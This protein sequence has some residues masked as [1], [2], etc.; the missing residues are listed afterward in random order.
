MSDENFV[1]R[2]LVERA[3]QP[4]RKAGRFAWH[5]ARGKLAGDQIFRVLVTHGLIPS[6]CRILD[7]GCGQALLAAWLAAVWSSYGRGEWPANRPPAPEMV[8]YRGIEL[9]AADLGWGQ[10]ALG[11]SVQ[12]EQGDIRKA[13]FGQADLV[14]IM[15]VLHYLSF[16]D[17]E[18]ILGRAHDALPIGG[19][20]L[21]RV[22]D[23]D[24]GFP[25][26]LSKWIDYLVAFL[27]WGRTEPLRCRALPAWCDLLRRCGF[28]VETLPMSGTRAFANALLIAKRVQ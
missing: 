26:Q 3:A 17:Q 28:S 11:T 24:A 19:L 5:F 1:R 25:F 18:A 21:T 16:A 12:L 15:D 9:A 8:E 20:L 7:L 13:E 22:G 6:Q 4:Y 2:E 27:R 14:V 10:A 23:A